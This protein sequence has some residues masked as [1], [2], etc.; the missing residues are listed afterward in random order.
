M[1]DNQVDTLAEE[2]NNKQGD[3]HNQKAGLGEINQANKEIQQT[4]TVGLINFLLENIFKFKSIIQI[5][6]HSF[7]IEIP[8]LAQLEKVAGPAA[9]DGSS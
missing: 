4:A 7:H 2:Q 9:V 8:K 1:R 6:D 5:K 3:G